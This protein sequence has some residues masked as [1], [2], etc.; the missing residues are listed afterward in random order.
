M[1]ARIFMDKHLYIHTR[2]SNYHPEANT[3][4]KAAPMHVYVYVHAGTLTHIRTYIHTYIDAYIHKYIHTYN[5]HTYVHTCM[6]VCIHTYIYIYI[7]IYHPYVY[8]YVHMYAD[9]TPCNSRHTLMSSSDTLAFKTAD[10]CGKKY[11]RN[12]HG[13]VL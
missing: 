9:I 13:A 4:S 5:T 11:Q 7:Y 1:H 3:P 8:T 12:Q 2:I 6:H 10:F